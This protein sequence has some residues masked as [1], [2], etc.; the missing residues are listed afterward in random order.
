MM[1]VCAQRASMHVPELSA[2]DSALC[3]RL[4][5]RF[6]PNLQAHTAPR[7]S[8]PVHDPWTLRQGGGSG[9][10]LHTPHPVLPLC[11]LCTLPEPAACRPLAL[12]P[13]PLQ[14]SAR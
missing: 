3:C 7:V 2:A 10:R 1:L 9:R 13:S 4:P 8:L 5:S 14:A 12:P 11:A 6:N